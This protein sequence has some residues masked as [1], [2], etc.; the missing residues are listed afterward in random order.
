MY[1]RDERRHRYRRADLNVDEYM[2]KNLTAR[3]GRQRLPPN[4]A[5]LGPPAAT[6]VGLR[7]TAR[8]RRRPAKA[9]PRACRL[10]T[11]SRRNLPSAVF[12]HP[13]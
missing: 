5:L 2:T 13:D 9:R 1:D 3:Q 10:L 7:L 6:M 4:D 11:R 8:V 12:C